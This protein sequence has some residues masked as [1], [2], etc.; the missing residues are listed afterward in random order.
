MSTQ[1]KQEMPLGLQLCHLALLECGV[2]CALWQR[3][4]FGLTMAVMLSAPALLYLSRFPSRA[5]P[6]LARQ[7]VQ[8]SMAGLAFAWLQVR[9]MRCPVDIAVFE[10]A[11]ILA[12]ALLLGC[13]LQEHFLMSLLCMA[14][15]GY[16]GL[17]PGRGMYI[18]VFMVAC[19]AF[20]ATTY[21]SRGMVF[22]RHGER[23]PSAAPGSD[24]SMEAAGL[25]F[26]L[27]LGAAL[28]LMVRIPMR[29]GLSTMGLLPVS[30]GS[31]YRLAFP[32][33]AEKWFEPV[34]GLFGGDEGKEAEE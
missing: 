19:L 12:E 7:L 5:F 3:G 34:T 22:W 13:R 27:A 23:R 31:R 33:L 6:G 26:L 10:C 18:P 15:A 20:A 8:L 4:D 16:G 11:A 24:M 1:L 30:F 14:F 17:S 21:G 2:A 9:V 32:E 29:N 25:H 28:F